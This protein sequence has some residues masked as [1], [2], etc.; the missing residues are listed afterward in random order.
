M[1]NC[2]WRGLIEFEARNVFWSEEIFFSKEEVN[3]A[4]LGPIGFYKTG[5]EAKIVSFGESTVSP[6]FSRK[7]IRTCLNPSQT[8]S[9]MFL[10]QKPKIS[11]QRTINRPEKKDDAYERWR[12]NYERR[13]EF[14]SIANEPMMRCKS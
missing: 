8:D 2:F 5:D 14:P 11:L 3:I 4:K 9:K 1:V 7:T 6:T 13:E 12:K 10:A